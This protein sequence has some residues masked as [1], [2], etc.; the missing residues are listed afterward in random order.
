MTPEQQNAIDTYP[1]ADLFAALRQYIEDHPIEPGVA[2]SRAQIL[3][4]FDANRNHALSFSTPRYDIYWILHAHLI[5]KLI[6]GNM[7]AGIIRDFCCDKFD[8][9]PLFDYEE[10][11]SW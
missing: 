11:T 2:R 3:V 8:I 1:I 9:V 5:N 4:W 7:P 6:D 10:I